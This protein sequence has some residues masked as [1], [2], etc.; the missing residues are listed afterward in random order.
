MCCR[1]IFVPTEKGVTMAKKVD[2]IDVMIAVKSGKL[3]AFIQN[4]S[5]LLED[6]ISGERVALN[7]VT[8][9]CKEC[10][11]YVWNAFCDGCWVCVKHSKYGFR[12][13]DFCSYG[14]RSADNG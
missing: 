6:T 12:P 10:K 13:N 5:F 4:G 3:K 1:N 8:V 7:E 9:P 14:E 11:H 2:I